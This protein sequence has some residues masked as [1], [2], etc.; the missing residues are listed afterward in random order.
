MTPRM[1]FL[2]GF[3]FFPLWCCGFRWCRDKESNNRRF[4][5]YS[6]AFLLLYLVIGVGLGTVYFMSSL[7]SPSVIPKE[8]CM[9]FTMT[10]VALQA[11]GPSASANAF[12]ENSL[13]ESDFKRTVWDLIFELPSSS[14]DKRFNPGSGSQA[15]NRIFLDEVSD[16]PFEKAGVTTLRIVF[17]ILVSDKKEADFLIPMVR[18]W[19]KTQTLRRELSEVKIFF[20]DLFL[21]R[22]STTDYGEVLNTPAIV[23]QAPLVKQT[24]NNGRFPTW[25]DPFS[26]AEGWTVAGVCVCVWYGSGCRCR[27]VMTLKN[28][29]RLDQCV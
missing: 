24:L 21:D 3:I 14:M 25:V 7:T 4:G 16:I 27:C 19:I 6:L 13:F 29:F 5:R 17:R 10:L 28:S 23:K 12:K 11:G 26:E 15:E 18:S 1:T 20:D 9:P 8:H 22:I 2:L